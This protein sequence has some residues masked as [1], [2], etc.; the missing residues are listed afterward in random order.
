MAE[1]LCTA[2]GFLDPGSHYRPQADV[3]GWGNGPG[4]L[5]GTGV[6]VPPYFPAV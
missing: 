4:T 1:N 6:G 2:L 3:G 5:A